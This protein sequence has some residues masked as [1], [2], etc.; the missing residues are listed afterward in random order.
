MYIDPKDYPNRNDLTDLEFEMEVR[1]AMRN[2]GID[3]LPN[4]IMWNNKIYRFG[5]NKNCWYRAKI[6]TYSWG[7]LAKCL[8]GDWSDPNKDG[9]Y[10]SSGYFNLTPSQ[11]KESDDKEKKDLQEALIDEQQ[12]Q[13]NVAVVATEIW[14]KTSIEIEDPANQPYLAKKG[15]TKAYGAKLDNHGNL[16]IPVLDENK[17][18]TSIQTI[19]PEQKIFMP[20]SKVQGGY[21]Y[22]TE[23]NCADNTVFLCEG[24]ATAASIFEASH[25][26][27]YIAFFAKNLPAVA[28]VLTK[29]GKTIYI[30]ADN[31]AAKTQ[32]GEKQAK[33]AADLVAN[34]NYAVI[35]NKGD[36]TVT[37][38]NDYQNKFGDLAD[39]LAKVLG[40]NYRIIL[41]NDLLGRPHPIR[42]L[43]KGWIPE[44]SVG[45]IHGPSGSGKTNFV[46]N[47]ACTLATANPAPQTPDL[48]TKL[49]GKFRCKKANILYL[50]GEG[51]AGLVGRLNAWMID[52]QKSD[53]GN[54]AIINKPDN[55]DDAGNMQTLISTIK[56]G[57]PFG[58]IDLVIIDTVNRYMK[59]DENSAQ[60]TRNFLNLTAELNENF[61]CTILYVHHTGNDN[62]NLDRGRGSSAWRG[63]LDFE[64]SVRRDENNED[65]R[66]V[67][68]MK[69]KDGNIQDPLYGII[70]GVPLGEGWDDPEDNEPYTA[71]VWNFCGPSEVPEEKSSIQPQKGQKEETSNDRDIINAFVE[72]GT[73][74][75][76]LATYVILESDWKDFL[77]A[78][79]RDKNQIWNDFNRN[80]SFIKKAEKRRDIAKV[81]DSTWQVINSD[82]KAKIEWEKTT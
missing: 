18:I 80:S 77:R 17:K 44:H 5:H 6:E 4:A 24:F 42:W 12:R 23:N 49:D 52:N 81:N 19:S 13:A 33:A 75:E 45:M 64:I 32:E 51:Y 76:S 78:N 39:W 8:F 63:A 27:T 38:A 74:D 15:L 72:K 46:M 37:D 56:D 31:D 55:L 21:F 68:Q 3:P 67:K 36:K 69:M 35:P 10:R 20:G 50:C 1:D 7:R 65:I 9:K 66:V 26:T 70:K 59:G 61:N 2:K 58:S 43:V 47:L 40:R 30:I 60:D 73:W 57:C 16:I 41:A 54:F 14:E 82:W 11:K 34:C 28:Q 48:A 79:D 62:A 71:S 29:Q 22:I 53:V 25:R